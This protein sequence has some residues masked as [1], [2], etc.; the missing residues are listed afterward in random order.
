MVAVQI[1]EVVSTA[2]PFTLE[3]INNMRFYISDKYAARM[4]SELTKQR[5]CEYLLLFDFIVIIHESRCLGL[6]V[7]KRREVMTSLAINEITFV[8]QELQHVKVKNFEVM[9]DKLKVHIQNQH[10]MLFAK[11]K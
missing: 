11:I 1:C 3:A 9:Y 6:S 7:F 2:A 5:P 8:N 10:L 4:E